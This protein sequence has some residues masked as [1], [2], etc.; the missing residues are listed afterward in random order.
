M[1]LKVRE[2]RVLLNGATDIE[3]AKAMADVMKQCYEHHSLVT[4]FV[5]EYLDEDEVDE[6]DQEE[7]ELVRTS[8]ELAFLDLLRSDPKTQ[9][10]YCHR[11]LVFKRPDVLVINRNS[12]GIFDRIY[13]GGAIRHFFPTNARYLIDLTNNMLIAEFS[14]KKKLISWKWSPNHSNRFSEGY[15][16]EGEILRLFSFFFC[17]IQ[18]VFDAAMS[19]Y[20]TV[21]DFARFLGLSTS[22]PFNLEMW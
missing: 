21:T 16:K 17:L 3:I 5:S 11:W 6:I 15:K 14:F 20:S 2:G 12:I 22:N 8:A 4:N 1:R 9:S 18:R 13:R 19:F 7:A 10:K